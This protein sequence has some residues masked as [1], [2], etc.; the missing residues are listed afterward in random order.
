MDRGWGQRTLVEFPRE[1]PGWR[2]D[3]QE[4]GSFEVQGLQYY[5]LAVQ[6]GRAVYAS[7]LVPVGY[8]VGRTRIRNALLRSRDEGRVVRIA[9]PA[10]QDPRQPPPQNSP[11]IAQAWVMSLQWLVLAGMAVICL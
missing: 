4:N 6:R 10:P 7:V 8:N 2:I 5:N 9:P 1:L 3:N 11:R